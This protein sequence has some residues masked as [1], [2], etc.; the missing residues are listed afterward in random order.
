MLSIAGGRIFYNTNLGVIACLDITTGQIEWL[1]RYRRHERDKQPFS[2]PDRFRYRDLTPTLVHGGMI[3]CAPQDCAE[4]FALDAATGDLVWAT[5]DTTAADAIHLLG[6]AGDNLIVSGDRLLWIDRSTGQIHA[7]FPSAG[8]SGN[9]NALPSPRGLGRGLISGDEVYWPTANEILVFS[10]DLSQVNSVDAPPMT[11]RIRLD[12]RGSEGGNLVAANGWLLIA[13]PSRLM[14]F[15]PA[16][17]PK[18]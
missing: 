1:T 12:T 7:Q 4:L 10:T 2:L 5:P 3:Y 6:V 17:K 15:A 9:L 18:Q 16:P 14:A 13:T 11:R 8:T